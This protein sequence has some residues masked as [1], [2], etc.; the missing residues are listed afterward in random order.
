[1]P[2]S[3]SLKEAL[4]VVV[5]S[6]TGTILASQGVPPDYARFYG[7]VALGTV[8]GFS[9]KSKTEPE[10]E[11]LSSALQ[12]AM[13]KALSSRDFEMPEDAKE[14]LLEIFTPENALS[15]LPANGDTTAELKNSMRSILARFDECDMDTL[16]FETITFDAMANIEQAVLDDHGFTALATLTNT[17][18]ILEKIQELQ[19]PK[20]PEPIFEE[21]RNLRR[22]LENFQELQKLPQLMREE[23]HNLRQLIEQQ[24]RQQHKQAPPVDISHCFDRSEKHYQ[25]MTG[26]NGRFAYIKFDEKLLAGVKPLPI[27][28]K[29]A[30][31]QEETSL[32]NALKNHNGNFIFIGEGGTGK[33]T[34]LLRIWEDWL[35][36]KA[37]LP[38][39]VPLNEYNIDEQKNFITNYLQENYNFMIN[40]T[41]APV[42]L[43]LDGFNEI[44]GKSDPVVKE[45]KKLTVRMKT[46]IILTSRYNFSTF[47]GLE[48]FTGFEL[49]PLDADRIQSFWDEVKTKNVELKDVELPDGW[50]ALFSTPMMLSLFANTCAAQQNIKKRNLFQFKPSQTKGEIIYNYL[51]C[52][53]GKLIT[54][55][56][57]EK[58]YDAYIALFWAAPYV[59]W[60]MEYKGLFSEE[61]STAL[62]QMKDCF[63]KNGEFIHKAAVKFLGKAGREYDIDFSYNKTPPVERDVIKLF[64]HTFHLLSEENPDAEETRYT[65]RHQHFRDFLSALHIDNAL[66][67]ALSVQED[68]VIPKEI[69]E[70]RLPPYV[71]E[72]LGGYQGDYRNSYKYEYR[73]RLHELLDRLRGLDNAKTGRAVNNVIGVWRMFRK[74]R[75]IGENLS[76]LDLTHVP[77]NGVVFSNHR[78]V[79]R[80]D[81]SSITAATFLP[82]GHS[83]SV[84]SAI[85]SADGRLV[86]SASW[87]ETIKEWDRETGECLHTFRG[88]S[89]G[90]TSVV[91]SADGRRVLSASSFSDKT[92]KEWDRESGECLRTFKGHSNSVYSAVYSADGR[93]VLSASGDKTIKEWDR[94]TGECLHTF[95]GHSDGVTSVVYSADGRR[96]L[97]AG[98]DYTIKEWDRESGECLRTFEGHDNHVYSAVYSADGRRVLSASGD[99]T[100]MEWDRESGECL[101]T[102][103]GVGQKYSA[104]Y[105]PDRQRVLSASGNGTL[106]EWDMKSGKCL[107]TFEEHSKSAVSSAVYS[108]DGRRVLSVS[109]DGIL[110]EW[111]MESGECL[112]TVKGNSS[113]LHIVDSAVYSPDGRRVLS[114][115]YDDTVK[116]WDMES[117]ECLRTFKGHSNSCYIYSGKSAV[118]SP[119]GRRVLILYD[120]AIKELDR[121]S[122]E[123]MRTFEGHSDSVI[124]AGYSPD[125]R[126]VLSVSWDETIK[127][128]TGKPA[129]V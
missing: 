128:G 66:A 121:E 107:R 78:G 12:S 104:G 103:K 54:G 37:E 25:R 73:T 31:A 50:E 44:S 112:R 18:R 39:Y 71:I 115:S 89:D 47:H 14:A 84:A 5:G 59:A 110:M 117:G 52:Q 125:G 24:N 51:L 57:Q 48:G 75:L 86:L 40:E 42:V 11:R 87:D 129:S 72:M 82:H 36:T 13:S 10:R 95:R 34:S 94:E 123:C 99:G 46:R 109:R 4:A 29:T 19:S 85:H 77:L 83:R 113:N 114:A 8:K 56:Q 53:L 102:V 2:V 106:M 35:K 68:F 38:L 70:R 74:D 45:I 127:D 88:H 69:K 3:F 124:S 116:E 101:R 49:Q 96:V 61:E 6:I 108:P 64:V 111:D 119:D 33:T 32:Y 26:G 63:E 27:T 21:F 60:E 23:F 16:P 90:V 17:Y 22:I 80:F 76:G 62:E 122:G 105:S 9:Y 58:L 81:G 118:Y 79:S 65:F 126:R 30:D 7:N 43:L 67:M 41:D 98:W 100:L 120:K 91:Y 93:R 55:D 15:Y 20:L 97:S 92:I 1:M 28:V